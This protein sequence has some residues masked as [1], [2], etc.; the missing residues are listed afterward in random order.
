MLRASQHS[1]PSKPDWS[2]PVAAAA[3]PLANRCWLLPIS[4]A[5]ASALDL[6]LG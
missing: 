2:G 6:S 1:V 4:F 5:I 3:S